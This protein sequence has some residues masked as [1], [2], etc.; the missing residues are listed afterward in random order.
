MHN[1]IEDLPSQLSG[2][3]ATSGPFVAANLPRSADAQRT[4]RAM[5]I[6]LRRRITD[7]WKVDGSY[8]WSRFEGNFD[9]D[10]SAAA[11]FNT[12][13]F[14]QDGPGTNVEEPNR[15]GPLRE[16]R[17]HLLKVF[18]NVMPV[19]RLTVGAYLRVQSGAPWN[20]RGRDTQGAVLNYLEPAGSRRNPTW[21]NVDLLAN[22]RF[23]LGS[24]ASLLVEGRV[25]N[26]LD[27]QTRLSTDGQQFL[28][29]NTIC[30][31]PYIGPYRQDNPLFGTGNAFAPPRRFLLAAQ[32][33][34]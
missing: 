26:L 2:T 16:D 5:T 1:F 32:V 24:R 29:L 10:Y 27:A 34:F 13:S 19:D 9:L 17:P 22:Y 3:S 6:D 8:T 23:A 21:T 15:Q 11:V 33:S 20:A 31:P 4:Y 12:S 28:D 30:T 7:G 18:A 25:L 14:I